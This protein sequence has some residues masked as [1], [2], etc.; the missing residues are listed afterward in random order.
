[1]HGPVGLPADA[2]DFSLLLCQGFSGGSQGKGEL[3]RRV[4][5]EIAYAGGFFVHIGDQPADRGSAG[6]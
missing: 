2:E 4:T 6:L 3:G 1:V 5:P